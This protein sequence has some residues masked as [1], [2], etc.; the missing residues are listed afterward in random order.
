MRLVTIQGSG[1]TGKTR[2]SIE[3]AK[4]QVA[5]FK[6]GAVFIPLAPLAS[7]NYIP[8]A[9]LEAM[10]VSVLGDKPVEEQLLEHLEDK[11]YLL[12]FDNFEHIIE[13]SSLLLDLLKASPNTK[14]IVTS[15]EALGFQ[16]EWIYQLKGLPVPDDVN[17]SHPEIYD[18]VKL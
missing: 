5:Q 16:G 18:A 12:L 3:V 14:I 13:G 10:D 4:E 15:R 1:G 2:L 17:E 9:I 7:E 11:D 8:S 6:D